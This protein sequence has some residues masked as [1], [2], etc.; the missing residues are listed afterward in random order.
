M[1]VTIDGPAG[2]GKST[3][4]RLLARRL[5][6]EFLDTGALYRMVTLAGRRSESDPADA[7]SFGNLLASLALELRRD[8]A[9]LNG[10]DVT[11][12]IRSPEI[13]RSIQQFADQR[14]VRE[15]VTALTRE[16]AMGKNVVT[17]GRDQGTVVFPDAEVKFFLSAS[18]EI[19]AQRRWEE[20]ASRGVVLAME[21][22]LADQRRRDAQDAA[23]PDGALV[24]ASDAI[25]VDS[26]TA[27]IDQVIDEMEKKARSR[28]R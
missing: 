27:S 1:I 17:E 14:H 2:A 3:V 4:A 15:F 10:D 19:R 12:D 20:L 8:R 24:R 9:F 23:R 11:L 7:G 25:L 28:Q 5:G 26:S 22:V 18:D 16:L 21:D 13:T 6:F